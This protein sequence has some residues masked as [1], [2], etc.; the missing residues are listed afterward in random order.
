MGAG[1]ELNDWITGYLKYCDNTEPPVSY[2]LWTAISCIAGC[3]QRRTKLLWGHDVI[4]PNMY[5]V[6]VGPSGKCRKGTAM[7]I[8][9]ELIEKTDVSIVAEAITRERLIQKVK[10]S[11]KNYLDPESG[12]IKFHCSVTCFSEELSVFLGQNDISFLSTLTN[13]FDSRDEWSYETKNAGKDVIQGVCFNLLGATAPDWIP[14]MFPQEAIGGGFTSRVIF[15]T[16]FNKAKAVPYHILT[17]AE[18]KLKDVLIRDL[19]RIANM[20]GT[21]EFTKEASDAYVKWYTEQEL[22]ASQ[23]ALAI[24]DPRFA[25][26]V[27]RRATHARKLCMALSAS[28]DSE[29]IITKQ[30]FTR[31]LQVLASVE[32]KMTRAFGGVGRSRYSEA[33]EQ[34]LAI[35]VEKRQVKRSTLMQILYRDIDGPTLQIVEQVLQYMGVLKID[36]SMSDVTYRYVSPAKEK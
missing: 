1:R 25:G 12:Q 14:S 6:L 17:P 21:F 8:G 16:E 34:V 22:R 35:L 24:D 11:M 9:R 30:D 4:Y 15:V 29:L 2:H 26:Y 3:L 18:L 13:W 36:I 19:E 32:G 33:V 23:G 31:A 10:E 27:E 20:A 5:I 7:T 28:R